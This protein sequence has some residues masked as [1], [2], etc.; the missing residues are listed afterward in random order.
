M[1]GIVLAV[2]IIGCFLVGYYLDRRLGTLPWLSIVGLVL[3]IA[4]GFREVMR[5]VRRFAKDF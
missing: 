5:I 2:S 1:V 4:A 3:G